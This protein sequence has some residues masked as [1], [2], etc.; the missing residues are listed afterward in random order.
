MAKSTAVIR[1]S[2]ENYTTANCS[3]LSVKD[4]RYHY[5]LKFGEAVGWSWLYGQV[6]KCAEKQDLELEL[7]K[8]RPSGMDAFEVE[9]REIERRA[10]AEEDDRQRGLT[11][12]E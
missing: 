6:A 11:E 8:V 7:W 5:H 10:T 12:Y 9:V 3:D 4:C 1:A 2:L